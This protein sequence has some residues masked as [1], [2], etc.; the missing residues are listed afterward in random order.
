[1]NILKFPPALATKTKCSAVSHPGS[2][3]RVLAAILI[4][5]T[6]VGF[7]ERVARAQDSTVL[8]SLKNVASSGAVR[9]VVHLAHW[10]AHDLGRLE[11]GQR[12]EFVVRVQQRTKLVTIKNDAGVDMAVEGIHCTVVGGPRQLADWISADALRDKRG[13]VEFVCGSG[14]IFRCHAVAIKP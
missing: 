9:C 11:P 8:V 3:G 5:L 7:G 12:A 2:I 10:F 13:Q 4:V 6:L 14:V 1:M